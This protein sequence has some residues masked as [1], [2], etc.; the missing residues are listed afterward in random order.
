MHSR[1]K[2]A[3]WLVAALGLVAV[4]GSARAAGTSQVIRTLSPLVAPAAAA[5]ATLDA[6][7]AGQYALWIGVQAPSPFA[8]GDAVVLHVQALN[9]AATATTV[10]IVAH[11]GVVEPVGVETTMQTGARR[12][13]FAY[14][15]AAVT[16]TVP[17][18]A[19]PATG[20][21]PAVLAPIPAPAGTTAAEY[22]AWYPQGPGSRVTVTEGNVVVTVPGPSAWMHLPA[23]WGAGEVVAQDLSPQANFVVAEGSGSATVTA[24][25]AALVAGQ[26]R[27]VGR[28][29][30]AFTAAPHPTT[31]P[32]VTGATDFAVAFAPRPGL[33]VSAVS[34]FGGWRFLVHTLATPTQSLLPPRPV[35]AAARTPPYLVLTRTRTVVPLWPLAVALAGVTVAVAALGGALIRRR[36]A[37]G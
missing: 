15:Q 4:G 24:N 13:Q 6:P 25:V 16:M 7:F 11:G 9:A 29:G 31:L 2:A 30:Y 26:A 12:V 17:G 21:G 36:G 35:A 37:S 20:G 23:G 32:Q 14:G 3:V 34:S 5:A 8:L 33:V 27:Q 28:G 1:R 18:A 10:R 22:V 19:A